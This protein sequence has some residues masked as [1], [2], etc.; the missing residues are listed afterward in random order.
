MVRETS[1]SVTGPAEVV[2]E[3]TATGHGGVS[4]H[5][6]RVAGVVVVLWV[7]ADG[8]AWTEATRRARAL[9]CLCAASVHALTSL[10]V[11]GTYGARL[12][13]SLLGQG[14]VWS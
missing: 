10:G 7:G 4:G 11:L 5:V 9:A 2:D 3:V 8:E 14:M 1:S 6:W 13:A 12:C